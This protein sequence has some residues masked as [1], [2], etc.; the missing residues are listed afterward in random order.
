MQLT[1]IPL[2]QTLAV[3]KLEFGASLPSWA[4]AGW[5]SITRTNDELSIVC[6]QEAVPANVTCQRGWRGLRVAG[7]MPFSMVG[8]LASLAV[9]LA[10]AGISLF[11]LSTFDTD[12]VLVQDQDFGKALD[13]LRRHGH[14]IIA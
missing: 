4:V 13:A 14:T 2:Q 8:V 6:P 3:C 9:L 11:A 10:E 5:F 7:T 1:L 12:Y